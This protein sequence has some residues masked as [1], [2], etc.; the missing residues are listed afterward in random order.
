MFSKP[1]YFQKIKHIQPT[2]IFQWIVYR[3]IIQSSN[4]VLEAVV[5][6]RIQILIMECFVVCEVV[7][8]S[9]I[10]S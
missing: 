4:H 3:Q 8:H 2:W 9:L 10:E 6:I 5:V 1:T 7:W